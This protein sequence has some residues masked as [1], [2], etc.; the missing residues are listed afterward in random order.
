MDELQTVFDFSTTELAANQ[1]GQLSGRQR[2]TLEARQQRS[3]QLLIGMGIAVVVLGILAAI[4]GNIGLVVLGIL[5]VVVAVLAL[6]EYIVGYRSYTQDLTARRIETIQG[7][8]HYVRRGEAVM[9]IDT[10]PAGIRIGDLQFLLMEDQARA[11]EEGAIYAVHFAPAT[12]SLLSA[13]PVFWADDSEDVD[14]E[15]AYWEV[16]HDLKGEMRNE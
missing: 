13:E 11:F 5:A 8:V 16:Q 4:V 12:H 3:F 14:A 6:M 2:E 1:Q 10:H 15:I 7:I 9:G